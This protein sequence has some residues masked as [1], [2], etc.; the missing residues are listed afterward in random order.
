MTL[1][2]TVPERPINPWLVAVVVSLATFMEVLDTTITNVA[3]QHIA[4]SLAAST[5]ESTW[6][7]TS[8]LVSN[9]IILPLSGWLAIVAGRR[10]Y[11]LFCIAAFTAASLACGVA[12]S[13]AMLIMFR[14]LQGVAGGGL[15]PT[16]QSIILDTFPPEKRGAVFAITGITMIAAPIIGPTL[17]GWITDNFSW[18]WIFYINVPVGIIAFLLVMKLVKDPPHAR[19][20]GLQHI[21]YLGIALIAVGLGAMQLVLD[22]GQQDDWWESHFIVIA[23]IVCGAC[24]LTA[25]WWLLRQKDPVVDLRLYRDPAF[26]TSSIMIFITGFVLYGSNAL[27]PLMLQTRFGYDATL[28]GLVLSPGGIAVVLL[29]PL[30]ARLISRVQARWLI[31]LGLSLSAFGLWH[32][33]QFTPQTDYDTF[34]W[35]RITQVVGL[36]FLFIP[37]STLAFSAVP[38]EKSGKASALFALARNIG[39]SVGIAVTSTYVARHQQIH[40]SY[41]AE[42]LTPSS[43]VYQQELQRLTQL[44]G[45]VEGAMQHL[46]Q[47]LQQQ[48]AMLAY[49]DTYHAMMIMMMVAAVASLFFLPAN[50]PGAGEAHGGH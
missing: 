46:Y 14:L 11:F 36:P 19:A 22:K 41:L 7:L 40:Q 18:R 21:D 34:M 44:T 16:Q 28:A 26:R 1:A 48:A 8:Y 15:Q 4:G 39:G 3:L 35:M 25:V 33:A 43:P 5:D 17:G 49:I 30:T 9:G 38:R 23:A 13:L 31:A 29:M 12:T 24:L 2:T 45:S 32:S 27:L 47:T 20:Q 6:V 10:N 42:H 50:K 37:I